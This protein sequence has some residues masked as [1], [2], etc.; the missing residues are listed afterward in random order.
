MSEAIIL[1][2][3]N[4]ILQILARLMPGATSLRV[5]LHRWRGVKVGR[6]VWIGYDAIIETSHPEWVVIGDGAWVGIRATIIAHYRESKFVTIES[7][8]TIGP[9]AI[10]LP[11]VT[12]GR[13]AVVTAGSVVTRSVPPMTVVQGNP[14]KPVARCGI[15]M[16]RSASTKE[17]SKGLR[18]IK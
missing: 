5:L 10:I 1:G 7:G 14:A 4:R 3:K 9:G 17:F 16:R 8:A 12:I 15:A 18:P 11:G 6:R 2:T 13:D